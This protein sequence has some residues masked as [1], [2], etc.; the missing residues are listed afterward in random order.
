MYFFSESSFIS[1]NTSDLTVLNSVLIS[2][3]WLA[4]NSRVV[5]I[6]AN[7]LPR[8]VGW[9]VTVVYQVAASVLLSDSLSLTGA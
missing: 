6:L 1:I 8:S 7:L 5:N 3:S 2:C 9:D 4:S